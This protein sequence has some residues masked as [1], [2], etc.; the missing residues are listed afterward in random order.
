VQVAVERK[1]TA[2]LI[3][4]LQTGRLTGLPNEANKGGQIHRLM[5]T[6]DYVFICIEGGWE[7]DRRG[8]LVQRR[9]VATPLKGGMSEDALVKRVLSVEHWIASLYHWFTDKAWDDH[10]T[11]RGVYK[12]GGGHGFMPLSRFC[13][14]ARGLP[15]LGVAGTKAAERLFGGNLVRALQADITTWANLQLPM[16][17]GTR[18]LG[19]SKA[20]RIVDAC[21]KLRG[22]A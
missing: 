3:D 17:D 18:R 2:D 9:R 14:M 6:Y 16:K 21:R 10:T 22:E 19:E 13:E 4:S 20:A 11:L 15:D 12:P 1:T 5:E 7:T 8:R